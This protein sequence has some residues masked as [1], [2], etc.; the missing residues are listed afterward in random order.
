[1]PFPPGRRPNGP[2]R[3]TDRHPSATGR[4]ARPAPSQ[5][6]AIHG[7]MEAALL[8]R[9]VANGARYLVALRADQAY[10]RLVRQDGQYHLP[11]G[12]QRYLGQLRHPLSPTWLGQ[13]AQPTA[14]VG[15]AATD[16]EKLQAHVRATN[17]SEIAFIM[18]HDPAVRTAGVAIVVVAGAE[19]AAAALTEEAASYAAW[20]WIGWRAA[21]LR[22]GANVIGQEIGYTAQLSD[23][24]EAFLR[25]NWV[26]PFLSAS[27][28]PLITTSIGSAAL[29]SMAGRGINLYSMVK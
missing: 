1:M 9:S 14:F 24:I 6:M 13:H 2:L 16:L 19:V 27:G 26:S 22:F 12:T 15:P 8:A 10:D 25:I 28:V 3:P 5:A 20:R 23:P 18:R 4:P 7:E 11:R 29:S 21:G 17:P